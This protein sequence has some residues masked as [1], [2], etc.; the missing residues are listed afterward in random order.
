MV[1]RTGSGITSTATHRGFGDQRRAAP[2]K[3]CLSGCWYYLS[4][5]GHSRLWTQ[6]I[7]LW[8]LYSSFFTP[9][10]FGFFRGLPK[11]LFLLDVAGQVAFLV[12]IF[13]Q[14][15]LAYRDPHTYRMV[16]NPTAIALR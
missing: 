16:R 12:D 15:L 1:L 11:N 7:L 10:E 6:F 9:M 3:K 8:A 13:V 4:C 14:F 5:L 2:Y